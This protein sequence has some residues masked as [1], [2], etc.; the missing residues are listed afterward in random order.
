MFKNIYNIIICALINLKSIIRLKSH[1]VSSVNGG[2]YVSI[3][4]KK[5]LKQS[6][7][8]KNK[9]KYKTQQQRKK[10]K[11][12]KRINSNLERILTALKETIRLKRKQNSKI[13]H[14]KTGRTHTINM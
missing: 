1:R 5:E 11:D 2:I 8:N 10:H 12:K 3:D 6:L 9:K 14:E 4:K 13:E 7:Y